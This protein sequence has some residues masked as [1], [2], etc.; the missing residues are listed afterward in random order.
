MGRVTW[1][2]VAMHAIVAGFVVMTAYA[3]GGLVWALAAAPI[4]SVA[5][6]GHEVR[7]AA[8]RHRVT[9]AE[10]AEIVW[11]GEPGWSRWNLRL[12]AA[13]PVAMAAAVALYAWGQG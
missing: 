10:A 4:V 8:K 1:G 3:L 13:A 11:H 5:Y 7:T 9:L 2:A 6:V 12:Q